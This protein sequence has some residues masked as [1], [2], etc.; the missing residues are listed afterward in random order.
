MVLRI[1]NFPLIIL[2]LT[3]ISSCSCSDIEDSS[4][5]LLTDFKSDTTTIIT[6]QK[7]NYEKLAFVL[8]EVSYRNAT[9][10]NKNGETP[11]WIEFYN[12]SDSSINLSNYYLSDNEDLQKW[13]FPDTLLTA[14]SYFTLY[15]NRETIN[16]FSDNTDSTEVIYNSVWPWADS[17]RDIDPGAKL[18]YG[19]V[20]ELHAFEEV[21]EAL[22]VAVAKTA[23]TLAF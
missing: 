10:V 9:A 16:T 22:L 5:S 7:D 6:D 3:I 2:T 4:N 13:Q 19:V 12:K 17:H 20:G 14:K 11:H 21:K 18:I 15:A 1:Y 8:S 23:W